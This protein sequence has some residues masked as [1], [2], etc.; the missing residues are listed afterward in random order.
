M[1]VGH[2]HIVRPLARIM[3][4]PERIAV[5]A[6]A[7]IIPR[8]VIRVRGSRR[9]EAFASSQVHTARWSANAAPFGK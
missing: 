7:I 9:A 3:D 1:E 8:T 5:N 2:F 4:R 6:T